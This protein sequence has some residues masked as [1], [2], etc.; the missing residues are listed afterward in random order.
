M[1][2]IPEV[3]LGTW[4][5]AKDKCADAVYTAIKEVGMR[6][7]DCACDYGNEVEV[8]QGIARAISEGV[9][10]REELWITSKLWNTF[11]SPEHV[12]MACKK[13][14][15]DLGLDFVDLYLIHFPIS[16]KF[17]PIETRYPPEWIHDPNAAN[18]RI[19]QVKQSKQETW[20]AMEELVGKG[21]TRFIGV[22]NYNVQLL[23]DLIDYA[24]IAPF[25]LQVELHPY[26][27]QQALVDVCAANNIRVVAF[28]PFGG[29]SYVE[30][31]VDRKVGGGLLEEEGVRAIAEKHAKTPAQ[32]LLR[33]NLQR[34]VAVI[35]KSSQLVHLKE[36]FAVS[37]FTIAPDDM[38]TISALG[39]RNARFNDPGVFCAFMGGAIPIYA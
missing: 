9:V 11:H 21:L 18:P 39:V 23:T 16:M 38:S 26:L 3:G 24:K 22:C 5:I 7:I 30:L 27:P 33:W 4:K 14:L 37:D 12:E 17:V 10:K 35:P 13:S 1:Q 15:T 8:G 2:T 32:V 25:C 36:N 28:S 6:H 29:M 19:E 34:G 20:R 31:G